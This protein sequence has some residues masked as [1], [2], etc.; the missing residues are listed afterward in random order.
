MKFQ[1]SNALYNESD[2]FLVR[3][4]QR[5]VSSG[6]MIASY[7]ACEYNYLLKVL[8]VGN[9]GV[10]KSSVLMRFSDKTFKE[11]YIYTIGVDFK[12]RTLEVNGKRVKLQIWDTA[13]Q[14]RFKAFTSAYYRG[15]HGIVMVYDITNRVSFTAINNWLQD[16]RRFASDSEI[17]I[18]LLGNKCD[19]K[20]HRCVGYQE[21]AKLAQDMEL[22]FLECSAKDGTNI[23][24]AFLLIATKIVMNQP[25]LETMRPVLHHKSTVDIAT[26]DACAHSCCFT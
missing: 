11:Q 21:G 1:T 2:V 14:E 15:A 20:E 18:L 7:P 13:G 22:L 8:L 25:D 4:C 10:G 17:A 16:I 9:S 23:D 26:M 5:T 12:V 6:A 19:Q 24:A 3:E